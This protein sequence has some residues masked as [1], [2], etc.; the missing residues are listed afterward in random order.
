MK[1]KLL[2]LSSFLA[3][4]TLAGAQ[5]TPAPQPIPP[6][7]LPPP[8]LQPPTIEVAPP[9][10]VITFLTLEEQPVRGAVDTV[11]RAMQKEGLVPLNVIISSAIPDTTKVPALT[12]RNVMGPDALMLIATA[13]GLELREVTRLNDTTVVGWELRPQQ[14][15]QAHFGNGLTPSMMPPSPMVLPPRVAAP[16]IRVTPE[17]LPPTPTAQQFLPE[18]SVDP[19]VP[20][21]AGIAVGPKRLPVPPNYP[22]VGEVF[23]AG[24]SPTPPVKVLTTSAELEIEPR[25]TR[26]Y[27]LGTL[28]SHTTFADVEGSLKDVL[29]TDG[30][31]LKDLK[32]SFHEKT[33]VLVVNGLQ[34]THE[35]IGQF[36]QALSKDTAVRDAQNGQ[37]QIRDLQERLERREEALRQMTAQ[38]DEIRKA[39][40]DNEAARMKAEMELK[41]LKERPVQR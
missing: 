31:S 8:A 32:I 30:I 29:E 27:A 13:T 23:I 2:H 40:M 26:V 14:A 37:S 21:P 25:T 20:G 28:T 41:L 19:T 5:A 15:W 17:L 16:P 1:T 38:V 33:N 10:P 36:L 4:T 12:L 39:T 34:R 9:N 24:G 35:L 3:L 6:P 22:V 18:P 11:Q 7:A